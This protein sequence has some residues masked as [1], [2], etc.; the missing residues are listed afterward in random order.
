MTSKTDSTGTTNF[1]WGYENRLKQATKPNGTIVNFKYDALGRRSERNVN[2]TVWTKF[3]YNGH[4]VMLDQ[5]S[6]GTTV[7]YLNGLGIDNKLRMQNGTTISYLFRSLLGQFIS[8][9]DRS[10]TINIAATP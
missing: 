8:R 5:N 6:D 3:T 9:V 2:G 4:D 10:D 7:K 1:V